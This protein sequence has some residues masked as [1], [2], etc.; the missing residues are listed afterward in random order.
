[1]VSG[2]YPPNSGGVGVYTEQLSKK[3]TKKGHDVTVITRG[4]NYSANCI[5][6]NGI[7]I[8]E[9]FS[10][11]LYPFHVRL[12]KFFV[13]KYFKEISSD[14]DILHFQSPAVPAINA[15]VKKVA[16]IH[17]TV[18]GGINA[19]QVSDLESLYTK[20]FS[21]EFVRLE[22]QIIEHSDMILPIS[23]YCRRELSNRYN[24]TYKYC[25]VIGNGVDTSFFKRNS[26]KELDESTL[27]L[28]YVGR[29]NSQKGLLDLAKSV[30][31]LVKEKNMNLVCNLIGDGP[32]RNFLKSF[33]KSLKLEDYFHFEGHVNSKSKIKDFYDKSDIFILPSYYEGSPTALIEAMSCGL[34]CIA[35]DVGGIPELINNNNGI[36]ISKKD[37]LGLAKAILRVHDN[38][39]L[40]EKMGKNAE[41]FIKMNYDWD[42]I[43]S[44]MIDI[45][46]A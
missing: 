4:M 27:K 30:N 43:L 32:Y 20:L 12:H 21:S 35:T 44:K 18:S 3:L 33:I 19:M 39:D 5:F 41:K 24:I 1:M 45:Y 46:K 6:Q 34:P 40:R 16:T 7:R 17:G 23:E 42:V 37:Y 38:K 15:K 31:Y 26:K 14:F 22:R 28:L 11:P 2:E 10:P 25:A 13:T 8:Y 29:I 9:I 36:L